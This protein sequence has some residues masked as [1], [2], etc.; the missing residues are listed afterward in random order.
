[1]YDFY[2]TFFKGGYLDIEILKEACK[3][4]CVTKKEFKEIT[5]IEFID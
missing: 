5:G 1:M 2:Y 4:G 3:W